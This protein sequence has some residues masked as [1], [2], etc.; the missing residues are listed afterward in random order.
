MEPL[1]AEGLKV[2]AVTVLGIAWQYCRAPERINN[3]LTWVGFAV[4]SAGAY[5]WVTPDFMKDWRLSLLGAYLLVQAA[6][7][8]AASAKD[9]KVAPA[10]NS[11]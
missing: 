5:V 11:L 9:A 3:A 10:T 1:A 2:A 7:G 6:R 8:S 4:L